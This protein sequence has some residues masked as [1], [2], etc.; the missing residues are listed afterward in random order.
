MISQIIQNNTPATQTTNQ[1]NTNTNKNANTRNSN[2]TSSNGNARSIGEG[3]VYE[4]SNAAPRTPANINTNSNDDVDVRAVLRDRREQD[5]RNLISLIQQHFNGQADFSTSS[6]RSIQTSINE[7]S[8]AEA[9]E[10]VSEDGFFGVEQTSERLFNMAMSFA[11]GDPEVMEQMREAIIKGFEAAERL[12]GGELP[13]IS[14][15]T[16][17]AIMQKFD[18]WQPS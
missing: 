1:R 17:D 3:A 18:N 6:R 11:G 13:E 15:Q 9:Q 12:W 7:I 10:L 8:R 16:L 4:R 5:A 2:T 14:H